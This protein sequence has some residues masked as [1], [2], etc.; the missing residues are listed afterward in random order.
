MTR[1]FVSVFVSKKIELAGRRFG[2]WKVLG[3]AGVNKSKNGTWLCECD[4]G[5]Q[6]PVIGGHLRK[7]WSVSCGCYQKEMAANAAL[8][9]RAERDVYAGARWRCADLTNPQYGGRGIKFLFTSFEQFFAEL[10]PRP[11]GK[12]EKGRALYSIDRIN[13]DGHY[14]PGNVRWATNLEQ[15]L[16]RG[17]VYGSAEI[18]QLAQARANCNHIRWHVKRGIMKP[19]CKFCQG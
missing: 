16:N 4:C 12:D 3:F 1:E 5:V 7:G 11:E 19:D 14:E 17:V 6:K 18:A 13:N 9:H 10:G 15:V 2:R 8:D